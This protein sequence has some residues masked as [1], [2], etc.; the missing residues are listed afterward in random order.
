MNF[1]INLFLMDITHSGATNGVDRYLMCLID[2]LKRYPQIKVHW[3]SLL[4]D[5]TMLFHRT[6]QK[7]HYLKTTIPMP[8]TPNEIIREFFWTDKFNGAVFDIISH[9][10]ENRDNII[11]H[12]NTLN[13][14]D[15]A[16]Y[17]KKMYKV[18]IITHIH[19]I[20]WKNLYDR[21]QWKFNIL[22]KRYYLSANICKPEDFITNKSEKRAYEC[23][24]KI[25]SG[26]HCAKE[27]LKRVISIPPEKVAVSPNGM[28]DQCEQV[29]FKEIGNSPIEFLFVG[30]INRSKGIF[31][32][33]E[34]L[35]FVRD[36]GYEILLHVIGKGSWKEGEKIFDKYNDIP[37][38]FSG[39][40][41]FA[42]LKEY[43]EK[44]HI[45]LIASLHEQASY[46]GVEMSMFGM[47]V[48]T[49]A[50]D[51]LDEM[52]EDEVNAL[53][54]ST[55]FSRTRGLNV[56]TRL[57]ADKI[58]ELIRDREKRKRIAEGSRQLYLSRLTAS[59]M[60]KQVV[61]V[62]REVCK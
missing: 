40:V 6:E 31:H 16:V 12:T 19:C 15:L 58:L 1:T 22:Y 11:I 14:I 13:L 37:M 43:Y 24:D 56:N 2:G 32:I 27:F 38:N 41:P 50:V 57:M 33:L 35:R 20:A 49:T 52:F 47:P 5:D 48:V 8:Q 53:K 61:E 55:T 29:T 62:Y 30:T 7:G 17:I 10:F 54:V 36:E 3:I 18:K 25:I 44:C 26:T 59:R 39:S 60:V 9:L 4:S 46:V 34:A 42:T 45:G 51:G 21:S 28:D 23:A